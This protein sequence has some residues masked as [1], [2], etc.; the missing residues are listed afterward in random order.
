MSW[1]PWLQGDQGG[2]RG[3]IRGDQHGV[4]RDHGVLRGAKMLDCPHG[5]VIETF[6]SFKYILL[7]RKKGVQSVCEKV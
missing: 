3:G 6:P 2:D 5:G 7:R 1:E 4:L